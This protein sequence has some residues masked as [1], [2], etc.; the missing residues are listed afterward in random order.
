MMR[1]NQGLSLIEILAASIIGAVVA[2]GTMTAFVMAAKLATQ[3]APSTLQSSYRVQQ[4]LEKFRNHIACDSSWFDPSCGPVSP[5]I[6]AEPV[7]LQGSPATRSYT[8]TPID[9]NGD[10]QNDLHQVMV[11]VEWD[12]PQ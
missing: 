5:V 10:G 12:P 1:S 7:S 3:T 4:G 9:I 6:A 2:G 8:V 11:K